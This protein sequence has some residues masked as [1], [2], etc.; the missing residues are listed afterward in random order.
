MKAH[1]IKTP[2]ASLSNVEKW[3]NHSLEEWTLQVALQDSPVLWPACLLMV[4]ICH[5]ISLHLPYFLYFLW[6][7]G[8]QHVGITAVT[9]PLGFESDILH[10]R[11]FTLRLLTVA[12]W[13]SWSSKEVISW[14]GVTTKQGTVLKGH[15]NRKVGKHCS[16]LIKPVCLQPGPAT[17]RKA[18]RT[19]LF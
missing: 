18:I 11:Y 14:L 6:I 12:K 10:I 2:P 7:S 19:L 5:P 15:S 8:S 3:T 13:Q 1:R 16:R 17:N 9:T 4:G